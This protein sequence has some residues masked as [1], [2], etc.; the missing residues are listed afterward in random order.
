MLADGVSVLP[1]CITTVQCVVAKT[2]RSAAEESVEELEGCLFKGKS[3]GCP[4]SRS[5]GSESA[6]VC[7]FGPDR[8]SFRDCVW[9]ARPRGSSRARPKQCPERRIPKQT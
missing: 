7:P 5:G 6:K 4:W 9:C 1:A 3:S 2:L 8:Y